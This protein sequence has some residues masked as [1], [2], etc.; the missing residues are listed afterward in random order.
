[1]SLAASRLIPVRMWI[2]W[3]VRAGFRHLAAKVASSSKA[4]QGD[5]SRLRCV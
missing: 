2:S 3:L 5:L 1:M 4:F